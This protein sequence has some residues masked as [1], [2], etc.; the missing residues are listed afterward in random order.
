MTMASFRKAVMV[1]M[2]AG[3]F[4]SPLTTPP[5][6]IMMLQ[7][8]LGYYDNEFNGNK[9]HASISGNISQ[10]AHEGIIFTAHYVFYW[11]S[12][13]RRSF[14]TGRL[15]I[16][17][18]EMLSGDDTDDIDLRWNIITQK[19]ETKGYKSYW[20]GKGHTG[21]KSMHHLPTARGFANFTGFLTGAQSY[22]STDRWMND[23]PYTNDKYST[24]LYGTSI[25]TSLAAHEPT[26]PLFLYVP[27]QAV[28]APYDPVPG[29]PGDSTARS[30]YHG[31][32]WKADVYTGQM[33]KLLEDKQ[34]Y[35]NLVWVY[36]ADNGGRG[37]GSNYP[38]RGEKRT[39]YE[40]G[41]RVAAFVS[42]GLIPSSLRGTTNDIRFHIVDWY[43]T[44]CFLANVS[45]HDGSPTPPLPI[46]PTT[47]TKDIY[48]NETSWPSEDGVVIWDML[49]NPQNYNFTSAHQTLIL[50]REVILSGNYKL[51]TSQHGDT[52][53]GA[54]FFENTWQDPQGNWFSP[55]GWNQTCGFAV[56]GKMV[57]TRTMKPCLFD[58]V[59]DKNET[60]DLGDQQPELLQTMWTELNNSWLGYYH[61][62]TP[63]DMLGPCDP[64]CASLKW[65]KMSGGDN[66]G[67]PICGVP[68]CLSP[69]PPTP[70]PDPVP[71]RFPVVNQTNCTVVE[72]WHGVHR[73]PNKPYGIAHV[74]TKE[75][76]CRDCYLDAYC[77][78]SAYHEHGN[79]TCYLHYSLEGAKTGQSGVVG[80]LTNRNN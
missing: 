2:L 76:C 67:G 64:V 39:N 10:L 68:G 71:K 37:D 24:D 4:S 1:A 20:Y 47:P 54:D 53:Q 17:H 50:S 78:A 36:S 58:L 11:C 57:K 48:Q 8:D 13:T 62:R 44:F 40:G 52:G 22:T 28:H 19:L 65:R 77:V 70:N 18:G 59:A 60:T 32:L 12:P 25:L 49:M 35:D 75:E 74:A 56:Y 73:T 34:M 63:A 79:N 9:A 33:R 3:A 23:A 5:H 30:V 15:P 46:D 26:T 27:W 41:M 14:L 69:S 29:W 6:I 45:H 31:M 42:G 72:G 51:L 61:S 55:P 21:Y 38:L 7:D 43:S 66:D 16:H 80:L